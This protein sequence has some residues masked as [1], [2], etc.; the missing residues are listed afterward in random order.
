MCEPQQVIDGRRRA[1]VVGLALAGCG[2]ARAEEAN[3]ADEADE[4]TALLARTDEVR[5]PPGAFSL[6][7]R[8][9]EYRRGTQAADTTLTV[10]A[11]PAAAGGAYRNLL[12]FL[13]PARDA[14]KLML[15]NGMDLW[16]YDPASRASVRVSPQQRL[17]GQASNGDVMTTQLVRDYKAQIVAHETVKDG[18][19]QM[20][21]TVKLKLTALRRDVPYPAIDYWVERSTARPVMGRYYT[22]ENRLLKTA[23]F[24]K[25]Q[26]V[27]GA[28]RP[29]E[30]V[31]VDGLDRTWITLMQVSDFQPREV[32]DEWLQRDY[33]ARFTG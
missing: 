2:W 28:Q 20:R 25:Y 11:K 1:L 21:E 14:G 9:V 29:T 27:M 3:K 6:Q 32:P 8:L 7:T 24:R 22:T 23:F 10:Y 13:A 19:G 17:L 18:E 33:L 31:I 26:A 15:R 5:N 16:F 30:T 4:A 12:R